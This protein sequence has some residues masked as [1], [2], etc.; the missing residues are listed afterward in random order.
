MSS[1]G[2]VNP[3]IVR[4]NVVINEDHYEGISD[5]DIY[6]TFRIANERMEKELG[7]TKTFHVQTILR[8]RFGND[9]PQNLMNDHLDDNGMT[10]DY[11][12]VFSKDEWSA[13]Y[14]GYMLNPYGMTPFQNSEL[15]LRGFCSSSPSPYYPDNV[16][17]GAVVDWG[18]I[19]GGCGYD[20]RGIEHVEVSDKSFGGQ[21]RNVSGLTCVQI[22][23]VPDESQ[24]PNLINDPHF[25]PRIRNRKLWMAE[26]IIHELLH[27]FGDK[28]IYD[29][30]CDEDV[31]EYLARLSAFSMCG[32]T[33]FNLIN[34][35]PEK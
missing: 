32:N 22:P 11:V 34:S 26:T 13:S 29:H 2:R 28:G 18:H 25:G 35:E 24:C 6:E 14:G 30:A 3:N 10:P 8:G 19:L 9:D 20:R 27:P 33:V 21:C 17:F 1:C 31:P 5:A 15:S 23:E 7:T 4:V 12:V 16:I